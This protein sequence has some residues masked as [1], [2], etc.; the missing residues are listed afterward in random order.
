MWIAV[1]GGGVHIREQDVIRIYIKTIKSRGRGK[2]KYDIMAVEQITNYE[3]PLIRYE[4]YTKASEAL[5][6]IVTAL[7][8]RRRRVEL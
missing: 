5:Y 1:E 8:E 6:K 4:D 3:Q 7:D 2:T